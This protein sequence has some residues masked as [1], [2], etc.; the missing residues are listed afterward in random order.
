MGAGGLLDLDRVL[1][2]NALLNSGNKNGGNGV[3]ENQVGGRQDYNQR[4]RRRQR[5]DDDNK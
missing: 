4:I 3:E 5:Q 1:D 2:V